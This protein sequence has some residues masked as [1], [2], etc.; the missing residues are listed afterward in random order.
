MKRN[1]VNTHGLVMRHLRK[2]V[3][4]TRMLGDDQYLQINYDRSDG[5]V[6]GDLF[7]GRAHNSWNRYHSPDVLVI[8]FADEAMKCQELADM[9][10]RAV[11]YH[12]SSR[13]EL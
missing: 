11:W 6:W 7:P 1:S 5:E 10:A 4:E 8:C 9:I 12:D 3:G 2:V 13:G